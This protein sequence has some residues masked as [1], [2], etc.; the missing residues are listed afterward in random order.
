MLS[1]PRACR[2][3]ADRSFNNNASIIN[4]QQLHI[5]FHLVKRSYSAY[6]SHATALTL[7]KIHQSRR[8]VESHIRR[9]WHGAVQLMVSCRFMYSPP[10]LYPLLWIAIC[11]SRLSFYTA[12]ENSW[13]DNQGRMNDVVIFVYGQIR[14]KRRPW[15]LPARNSVESDTRRFRE[16]T[17]VRTLNR[18][19]LSISLFLD[20]MSPIPDTA[21]QR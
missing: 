21:R 16:L 11:A 12:K 15:I 18:M 4:R 6:P 9:H 1:H 3:K 19:L 7:D 2:V 13:R 5:T 14:S 8:L 20:S 17:T 10:S